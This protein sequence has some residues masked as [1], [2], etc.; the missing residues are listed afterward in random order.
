MQSKPTISVII[1][2]Y[3]GQRFLKEAIDSVY[4]QTFKDWEIIFWDN[5][6]SDKSKEIA[7]SYDK[8]VKIFSS[9]VTTSLGEARN[10]ALQ[11][12]SGKYLTFLDCDDLFNNHKL[13]DQLSIF[14]KSEEELGFVYGKCEFFVSD[15]N[16]KR[17]VGFSHD[18]LELK[19]G[20]I[21]SDLCKENFIPWP[22]VLVD[23]KKLISCGDIPNHFKN[24]VD[25][26]I[27]MHLSQRYKVGVKNSVV[28]KARGHIDNLAHG[29]YSLSARENIEIVSEFL[30]H[31]MAQS[32][33]KYHGV[34]LFIG[35]IKE[36]NYSDAIKTIFNLG[37]WR[38]LI[39]RVVRK[40]LAPIIK[41]DLD[42]TIYD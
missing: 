40:M 4:S 27:F 23:R 20:D 17:K 33:I 37:G 16:I 29:Q 1:N 13:E 11:E 10:Y 14:L 15:E 35:Y 28:S 12:A 36:K 3:N 41:I 38:L 2:C 42:L 39:H 24:S 22:S 34:N 32:G 19:Y 30:P 8:K 18:G 5:C 31:K 7:L 6:S 26:W 21:F 9:Q 25:Y